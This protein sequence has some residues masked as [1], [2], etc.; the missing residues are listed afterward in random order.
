MPFRKQASLAIAAGLLVASPLSMA[1]PREGQVPAADLLPGTSALYVKI[2]V[3]GMVAGF[4]TL[5]L[6]RLYRDE[7]VQD[8]I[9]PAIEYL[10]PHLG[11]VD[12]VRFL[13]NSYG[14]PAVIE[15]EV[16][17]AVA[18]FGILN[19][20]GAIGWFKSDAVFSPEAAQALVDTGWG[21]MPD[22]LLLVET[23]GRESFA[24][25]FERLLE[26]PP[27]GARTASRVAG[28]LTYQCSSLELE[29]LPG[30]ALS[31]YHGFV[32]DQFVLGLR[33]ESLVELMRR[34]AA[35]EARPDSLSHDPTFQAWRESSARGTELVEVYAGLGHAL[36]LLM[37]F[38]DLAGGGDDLRAMG[39][40]GLEGAGY[41]LALESGRVRESVA[42]VLP[43]E[44]RGC[45]RLLDALKPSAA[46][47]D[48]IPEDATAAFALGIDYALLYDRIVELVAQVSPWESERMQEDQRQFQEEVGV[49]L[50]AELL[51]PIGS[52]TVLHAT[53]PKTGFIPDVGG[54]IEIRD[55]GLAAD[56]LA[57]LRESLERESG[58]AVQ[59]KDARIGEREGGF[60]LMIPEAPVAP[61]FLLEADRLEFAS[62]I[63][64]LKQT[65]GGAGGP[66]LADG[67]EDF[68]SCLAATVGRHMEDLALV[69]YVDLARGVECGLG[70]SEMFLPLILAQL[71]FEMDAG[72]MPLPETVSDYLSGLLLTVRSSDRVVAVD[73]LSPVG[74]L[75]PLASSPFL[76]FS[77]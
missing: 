31:L 51:A 52:R 66:G 68:K 20:Q 74:G 54:K 35:G 33:E 73:I 15:G 11:E 37:P 16:T 7:E 55:A 67:S 32:G 17:A 27:G 50:R 46:L 26:L 70:L 39:L 47:T 65:A 40:D 64:Y 44:R 25:M 14:L 4:D 9:Q 71:P 22:L 77:L 76:L 62:S 18:G 12:A 28:A 36:R 38:V 63:R 57:R 10:K 42:A 49:A 59:V 21:V 1:A 6:V 43:E 45:L 56:V 3:Q 58:G 30:G 2:D 8:F 61:A 34:L 53:L 24:S 19:E 23:A 75:L 13:M 29:H 69:F 60:Y 5:D 72:L 41:A 48:G